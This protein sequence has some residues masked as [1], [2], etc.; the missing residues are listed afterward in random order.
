[1]SLNCL[2][3][4]K[5]ISLVPGWSV[6]KYSTPTAYRVF[7]IYS[8]MWTRVASITVQ[9]CTC[10][11]HEAF[12]LLVFGHQGA[13]LRFHIGQNRRKINAIASARKCF[14]L[15]SGPFLT[16]MVRLSRALSTDGIEVGALASHQC[17]L[18][19]IPARCHMWVEFV[20]GSRLALRVFLRVLRFSSLHKNQHLQIPIQRNQDRGRTRIKTS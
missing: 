14:V 12:L 18:E 20:V 17:G 8:C 6:P 5:I 4:R 1:M 7:H 13:R 11:G 10:L 19:S 2:K 3:L 15:S 9:P 16:F